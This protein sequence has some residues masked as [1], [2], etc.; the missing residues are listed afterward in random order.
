[1]SLPFFKDICTKTIKRL[2]QFFHMCYNGLDCI[3]QRRDLEN[4]G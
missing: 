3:S 4:N 2:V 1:M